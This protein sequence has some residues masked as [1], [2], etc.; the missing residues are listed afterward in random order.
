MIFEALKCLVLVSITNLRY[1]TLPNPANKTILFTKVPK[2][3]VK[4]S[5]EAGSTAFVHIVLTHELY[6]QGIDIS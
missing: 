4:Q 1:F 5:N 6:Q 3:D 2:L